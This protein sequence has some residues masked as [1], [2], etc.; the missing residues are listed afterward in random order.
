MME[1]CC[2]L[3]PGVGEEGIMLA[4]IRFSELVLL[5]RHHEKLFGTHDRKWE[6]VW[7]HPLSVDELLRMTLC[8][9]VARMRNMKMRLVLDIEEMNYGFTS[10]SSN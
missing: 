4:D 2:V 9:Y 6:S 5:Y 7:V 3:H 1:R 10:Y 8:R